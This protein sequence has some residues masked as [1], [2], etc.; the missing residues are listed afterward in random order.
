MG[1]LA[2][3]QLRGRHLPSLHL[4]RLRRLW[5]L[6]A[7]L[8]RPRL[9]TSLTSQVPVL[10]L[11]HA[12]APRHSRHRAMSEEVR[13]LCVSDPDDHA[14]VLQL[15]ASTARSC[16]GKSTRASVSRQS[17]RRADSPRLAVAW[18]SRPSRP[19]QNVRLTTRR[20]LSSSYRRQ[21]CSRLR[22]LA[23]ASIALAHLSAAA[24]R[25]RLAAGPSLACRAC[26]RRRWRRRRRSCLGRGLPAI[27]ATRGDRDGPEGM[28]TTIRPC[29]RRC[30]AL[31]RPAEPRERVD[32][33]CARRR[34]VS[35]QG[36]DRTARSQQAR[37]HAV[38]NALAVLL[39]SSA[40]P[41]YART[42]LP[43]GAVAARHVLGE[44]PLG[45]DPVGAEE[46]EDGRGQAGAAL[47][48]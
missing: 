10:L 42:R 11:H 27:S 18:R 31:A 46:G 20:S 4:G 3:A 2:Q 25:L 1:I 43:L 44:L 47:R 41:H 30:Q 29:K 39:H 7:V 16:R 9:W 33:L 21:G 48:A 19:M 24:P 26:V 37:D 5:Q 15:G 23:R 36:A 13:R 8:V 32:G 45:H 6:L 14:D 12:L 22:A 38:A 34:R 17:V 40:R 28:S 35:M